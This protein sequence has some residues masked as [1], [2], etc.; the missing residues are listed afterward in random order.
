MKEVP[1]LF[2]TPMVKAILDGRKT[3]TRRIID[4]INY[5]HLNRHIADWPL[6]QL[7]GF[8]GDMWAFDLQTDVDDYVTYHVK[9]KCKPGDLLWVRE[10]HIK[11]PGGKYHYKA[12]I[13]EEKDSN[14]KGYIDIGESWAKWKPSI[15]MPKGGARIWLRVK[16]VRVERLNDISPGDACDEG[17]EYDNVDAE[18]LNGGEL[19]AD[20]TNYMWRDDPTYEDY[21]F[22]TYAS[23]VDSYKSLWES[24]NGEGSWSLNPW[25]WVITFEVLS[26]TGK[27]E[28]KPE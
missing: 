23:C 13:P 8:N 6:S 9:P 25:V 5:M 4:H 7:R 1:I 28:T 19:V 24:I 18:A 11:T 26:T 10:T 27:P 12:D 22:P 16:E 15:H 17:I 2:S 3:Q 14:R 21:H 20:F